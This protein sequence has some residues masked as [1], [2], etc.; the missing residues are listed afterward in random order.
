V[1]F[2]N[3]LCSRRYSVT[4]QMVTSMLAALMDRIKDSRK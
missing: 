4:A 1:I 2:P 3:V